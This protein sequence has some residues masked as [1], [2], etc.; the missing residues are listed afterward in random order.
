[1]VDV[2]K[3]SSRESP[4]SIVMHEPRSIGVVLRGLHEINSNCK[5][6]RS[7]LP[8]RHQAFFPHILELIKVQL[9]LLSQ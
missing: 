5:G 9:T 8:S 7:F 3:K 2:E 4:K 1:M 6:C